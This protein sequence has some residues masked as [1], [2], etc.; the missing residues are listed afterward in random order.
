MHLLLGGIEVRDHCLV[1]AS[2]RPGAGVFTLGKAHAGPGSE[3]LLLHAAAEREVLLRLG[4]QVGQLGAK[5][6][7]LVVLRPRP[8]SLRPGDHSLRVS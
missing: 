4:R 6:A 8:L 1:P 5:L 3:V 2:V 7:P